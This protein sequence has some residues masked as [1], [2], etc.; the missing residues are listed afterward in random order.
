MMTALPLLAVL[1]VTGVTAGSAL[2]QCTTVD[3][4][5]SALFSTASNTCD[6]NLDGVVSAAD[7]SA[8]IVGPG[9]LGPT[10]TAT[11]SLT[12]QPSATPTAPLCPTA[13]AALEIEIDNQTQA[14]SISVSVT[15]SQLVEGCRTAALATAYSQVLDCS[16]TGVAVCGTLSQLAPGF[17]RHSIRMVTPNTHQVQHQTSLLIA[18]PFANRIGF[19]AFASVTEVST[20]ANAGDGSLRR[21]LTEADTAAKP[22]LIQFNAAA[23]PAGLPTAIHLEFEL[24]ALA[25]DDVTIDGTDSSG[26]IGNRIIDADG[27][28]IAALV[29]TGARNRIVGMRLRNAGSGE[30]DVV[31]I[32]GAAADG[33]RIER[34]IIENAATADGVGID[35]EAGKDFG[36]GANVIRE[37]DIS[38][39]ADKGV[40]VTTGAYARVER[41]AVHDNANGGI[42]A[43]LGGHVQTAHD[44]VDHNLGSTAQNG[45]SVN[46]SDDTTVATAPSELFAWGDLARRNGANGVSVRTLAV[47]NVQ[48]AYL[49]TNGSSGIRVFNDVGDAASAVVA[50][51]SAVCNA[52]DG[53]VV[54]DTSSADFGGGALG[55]LGN[56]AFTQNNLPAGGAN[57]RNATLLTV[58]AVNN[59]WEH[60]GHETTCNDDA[61]AAFD[62]SDHGAHTL[63]VPAQAHRSQQPPLLTG[64]SPAAG[65][66]GDLLRIFGTGFNVIDGHFSEDQ[67]AD[68]AGRNRCVPLRGNCVK[69]NGVPALVEAVTPT[70]LVVHWPFT[71]VQPVALVVTTDQG[72]TGASSAP[73][74]VCTNDPAALPSPPTGFS[75]PQ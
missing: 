53:A 46:A 49:A 37:C 50:G 9:S 63:F 70:M 22:L 17:W 25:S 21:A 6:V 28:S 12:P 75:L 54:A 68:V 11:P 18:D 44:A 55:S 15:G 72:A 42:Q 71:C 45:L 29:I 66:Q 61:I 20:A 23:F 38:G 41:C 13:G 8:A 14:Q 34:T 7:L 2:A 36:D 60:C 27:L 51:T 57:L 73:F 32:S 10:A 5:V 33:N 39:A 4:V 26:T 31:N 47:A 56:N 65:Q 1:L 69:I 19:T 59:Q 62:L 24:P 64:V 48:D 74:T 67:C 52:V 30:R 35:H 58:S 3:A 43:T 16:G 40:K